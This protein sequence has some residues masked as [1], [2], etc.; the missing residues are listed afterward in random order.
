MSFHA[1][2]DEKGRVGVK[3]KGPG[4]EYNFSE[5]DIDRQH[6]GKPHV[7]EKLKPLLK[8][9][10]NVLPDSPGEYQGGYMSATHERQK[11]ESGNIGHTPNT[12]TYKTRGSSPEGKKFSSSKVSVTVH[13]TLHGDEKSP[14]PITDMKGFKEHPDVHVVPH[15]LGM[16]ERT[17]HPEHRQIA[18]DHISK[19]AALANGHTDEH[20]GGHQT[21]LRTYY[22]STV[23]DG[24]KPTVDGYKKWTGA[25]MGK[26]VEK[27]STQKAKE[28]KTAAKNAS[29]NHIEQHRK[30]FET[31]LKIHGHLQAATNHLAQG[32]DKSVE[33]A[34]WSSSIGDKPSGGEGYVAGGMKIVDR[35]AFSKANFAN[36][37]KFK[38]K[39]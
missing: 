25:R 12:I 38:K 20:L 3:Y 32:L 6:A 17:P 10:G 7:S 22:N 37:E 1:I 24:S 29:L 36:A 16:T 2:R 15:V 39:P 5:K 27:V 34:S 8:H 30:A 9:L 13:T 35:D 26:E 18:L 11:D 4:S 33:N 21:N 19:A 28:S 23:R 14:R 31:T